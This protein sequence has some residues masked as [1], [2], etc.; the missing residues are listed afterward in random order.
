MLL[1]IIFCVRRQPD[2]VGMFAV[3]T[4]PVV[5]VVLLLGGGGVRFHLQC[6]CLAVTIDGDTTY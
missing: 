3:I 6:L 2:G 1:R 5:C 4:L